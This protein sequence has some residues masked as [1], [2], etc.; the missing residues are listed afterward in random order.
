MELKRGYKRTEVGVIPDDWDVQPLRK[1]SPKQSVGLVINPS[2]YFESDGT[3]PMLVGSNVSENSIEWESANRISD[4][5]NVAIAASRLSAG[6]LVTV[7]VGDPGITAVVPPELDGCNCASMMIVRRGEGFDSHWLCFVMNSPIGLSQVRNVQ[8]GTAQK[9]FNISDA[10]NFLYPVPSHA[11]Q[12][13][14]AAALSDVDALISSLDQLIAKKRGIKQATMQQL[15]TGKRRLPGFSGEWE[16]KQI[17]EFTECTAGG[18]PSTAVSAYWGGNIRWMSSGELNFKVVYEVSERI[19]RLGLENSS[20]KIIPKNCVLIG[21]AG[22]GKTRGTVA[23]NMIELCTN[24]SIAAIFPNS[25]FDSRYLY[26]NL[27]SRYDEL[28]ALSTGDGGRGG[29][30]LTIIRSISIPFPSIEEQTAIASVFSDMDAE[31]TTLEQKRDKTRAL[32]QGMMQELLTGKI[33]LV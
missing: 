31:I 5:S 23:M 21:L 3:I 22:Q 11:E 1:I 29:L 20:A 27:D 7:R 28:R 19:T 9:Q 25:E 17:G 10:V 15:L 13:A 26:Y 18:T 2:S 14:I 4:V 6:D 16:V 12:Q 8:Y 32:K 30:N 33:R 24:Q